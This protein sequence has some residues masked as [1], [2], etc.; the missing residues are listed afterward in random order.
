MH[1]GERSLDEVYRRHGGFI[2]FDR[3]PSNRKDSL[4]LLLKRKVKE[5]AD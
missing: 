3:K 2:S 1:R 4:K 5:T